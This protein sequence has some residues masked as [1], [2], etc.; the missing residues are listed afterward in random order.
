[1]TPKK[2][3]CL[4]SGDIYSEIYTDNTG[5]LLELKGRRYWWTKQELIDHM[6]EYIE[7]VVEKKRKWMYQGSTDIF[8]MNT[9]RR[10]AITQIEFTFT[11]GKLTD[12]RIVE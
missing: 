9:H 10:G 7:P 4:P 11:D 6:E 8:L 12:V 5:S 2:Y 1:M 3:L